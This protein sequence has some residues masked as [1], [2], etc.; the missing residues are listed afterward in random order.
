MP[1]PFSRILSDAKIL[2]RPEALADKP[3]MAIRVSEIFATWSKIEQMLSLVLVQVLGAE[4][5]PAIAMY[6]VLTS[7]H[8]RLLTLDAAAKTALSQE[9]YQA[10]VAV[11]AVVKR[12]QAPRNQLAHWIWGICEQRPDLLA[13]ANPQKLRERELRARP[14]MRKD[15]SEFEAYRV[16]IEEA[17]RPLD[18]AHVFAYSQDDLDAAK[19]ELVE[20]ELILKG[21]GYLLDP[22]YVKSLYSKN[23][24]TGGIFQRISPAEI[25][26][27]AMQLLQQHRLF[28]D[29][30]AQVQGRQA[31]DDSKNQ[32]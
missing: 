13:L 28:V 7:Q 25:R 9:D 31:K 29:A 1:H 5:N 2:F 15:I 14:L 8:L 18:L 16:E 32:P 3:Q 24:I 23:R 17:S 27:G 10:F 26:S 6:E 12:V 30:L 4:E 19:Q 11:M 21:L 22:Q 20:A